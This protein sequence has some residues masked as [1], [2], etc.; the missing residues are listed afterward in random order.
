MLTVPPPHA[1]TE[2]L[3]DRAEAALRRML[4]VEPRNTAALARLGDIERRRGD[5]AAALTAYRNLLAVAPGD[6]EAAWLIAVLGGDR[7]PGG[8]V[9]RAAPFVRLTDFLPPASRDRLLRDVLAASEQFD[10]ARIRFNARGNI[11]NREIRD[12]LVLDEPTTRAI[13]SWFVPKLRVVLPDVLRRLRMEDLDPGRIETEVTVHLNGGFYAAHRDDGVI[14]NAR[15]RIVSCVYYFHRAPRPFVGGDLLLHDA[16]RAG[17][18]GA[19]D[20][21]GAFSRI[22][23]LCN[24]IVFFP[25]GCLHEITPVACATEFG[26]GRFTVQ[27]WISRRAR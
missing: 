25:S 14:G 24:S 7:L 1:A 15:Y 19:A 10:P 27:N 11:L 26:D 20:P 21:G 5:F 13:R 9:G 18:G 17:R 8:A 22:E 16:G 4:E 12:A 6:A 2:E 23:P 3:F